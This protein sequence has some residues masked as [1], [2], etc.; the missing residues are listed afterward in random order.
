MSGTEAVHQEAEMH[1]RNAGTAPRAGGERG[2]GG[3]TFASAGAL[4]AA[5]LSALC[6]AGPLL[7]VTFGVGAGLASTFEPF[8]PVFTFLTFGLLGVGFWV[9]YGR[10]LAG[11]RRGADDPE[12]EA[13]ACSTDGACV[14]PR[15]RGREKAILWGATVAALVFWSFPY[16]SLLLI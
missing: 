4:G 12:A 3:G 2:G 11:G 15:S 1:E 16:W 7:F 6:C 13:A 8:R 10:P 5:G 14:V 9:V